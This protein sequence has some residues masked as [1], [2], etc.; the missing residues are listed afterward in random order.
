MSA[1]CNLEPV[2]RPRMFTE[3]RVQSLC[4]PV[5]SEGQV[6]RNPQYCTWV[7]K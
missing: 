1:K 5:K 6:I 3:C 4:S 2:S 7:A